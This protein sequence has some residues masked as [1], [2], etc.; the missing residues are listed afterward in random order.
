MTETHVVCGLGEVGSALVEVLGK[1]FKVI[2]LDP[3]KGKNKPPKICDFLHIAFPPSKR[4]KAEADA[5]I[6]NL[7]PSVVIVHSSV[8][9]GTTR[10]L[11][12]GDAV[13]SPI[14]GLHPHLAG[15]ML[16][17]RKHFGGEKADDAA[18]PFLALGCRVKTHN[19]PETTEL[20]KL[21]STSR[22][23]LA[24]LVAQEQ[25]AICREAGV[26]YMDAVMG[27][28]QTYNEG[29]AALDHHNV[30]QPVLH[31]PQT[32]ISG[33]CI[34]PNAKLLPG[35]TR[36]PLHGLLAKNDVQ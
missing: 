33:H 7:D 18:K 20:A 28:Q 36:T 27:Y 16:T 31:P 6:G 1:R 10:S 23:G 3:A 24:L 5:Y 22:Y 35:S 13:H 32:A 34:L 30:I 17:F 9:V 2:G 4:F 14:E 25:A 8:A 19:R 15:S 26:S 12:G 29:Y 11:Y 21:L